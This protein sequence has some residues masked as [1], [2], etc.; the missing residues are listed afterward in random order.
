M[1]KKEPLIKYRYELE[2]KPYIEKHVLKYE[3]NA[4]EKLPKEFYTN[5]TYGNSI[6]SLSIHL[7]CYNV[8]A[9]ERLSEFFR[10]RNP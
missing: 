10:C 6:K 9:Y 7:V 5:V 3:N 4:K 1:Q 8:I 2:I